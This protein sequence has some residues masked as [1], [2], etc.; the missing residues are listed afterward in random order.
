[1]NLVHTV[2]RYSDRAEMLAKIQT[3]GA[4]ITEDFENMPA[5]YTFPWNNTPEML[6]ANGDKVFCVR[7]PEEEADKL[8]TITS[9]TF[10]VDYRSDETEVVLETTEDGEQEV[11]RLLPWPEYEILTEG[12][13][14][15]QGVGRIA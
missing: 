14:R 2:I 11:E 7:L 6:C 4:T 13:T 3:L 12:G 9:P 5:E 1:M 8:N 15:M 10:L